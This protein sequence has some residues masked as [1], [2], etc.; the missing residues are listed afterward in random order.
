MK[1]AF[2]ISP[3]RLSRNDKY[4]DARKLRRE[5]I[6]PTDGITVFEKWF[7]EEHVRAM[8]SNKLIRLFKRMRSTANMVPRVA[9]NNCDQAFLANDGVADRHHPPWP[10][11]RMGF[12]R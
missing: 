10:Y 1:G 8:L 11:T 2:R 6:D 5:I 4:S 9:A 3:L 12:R 7:D